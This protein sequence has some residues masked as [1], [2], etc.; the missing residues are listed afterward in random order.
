MSRSSNSVCSIAAIGLTLTACAD[1]TVPP[2]GSTLSLAAGDYALPVKSM[3]ERRYLTVVR[4]QYDFSCGS[5]ALATL[6]RYHYGDLQNEQSIFVG[7]WRQGDREQ[8]RRLGFSLLDMKRYLDA[9]GI[10]ADGYVVTLADIE[11]TGIPGIALINM[12]GYKHFVVIKGVANGQVL[13]GDPSLGMRLIEAEHFRS[14]WNGILFA[15]G[16]AVEQGKSSF[17]RSE[18][19]GLVARS[20]ATM[21]MEPASLQALALTRAPPFPVEM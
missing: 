8:I 9:R 19:W 20:R 14:M 2:S 4:Q 3:V 16:D 1:R 5:A 17:G 18:E 12:K 10:K 11:A 6:L 7:M 21:L 13:V 15:L